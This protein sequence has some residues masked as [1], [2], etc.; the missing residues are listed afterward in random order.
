MRKL[1]VAVIGATGTVGQRII[2]LLNNH[3]YFEVTE[4]FASSRSAGKPYNQTVNW[5]IGGEPS[6]S[7]NDMIVRG[8]DQTPDSSLVFSALPSEIAA[9][10][11]LR[12]ALRGK[13]VISKSSALRY[14][15]D[16]PLIVP[17]VNTNHLRL[18]NKQ[19]ANRKMKGC[20]ITDPNCTTTGLVLT[21]AP[22]IDIGLKEVFVNTMQALSGAGFPGVASL[23][24]QDNIIPYIP[25]EE[26]KIRI[27]SKKILGRY[28]RNS[29]IE[30]SF[31]VFAFCS[32]VPVLDCHTESVHLRFDC[33]IDVHEA[34]SILSNF[35]SE[36]QRLKLHSAP[37][38]PVIVMKQSDRPQPRLDKDN[39]KGMSTTVGRLRQ[40][41]DDNSI[42]YT[43]C[44]HNTIRGAAGSSILDAE[45]LLKT[46]L[47]SKLAEQ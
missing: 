46:G 26:E 8:V 34:E 15:P 3:P 31:S 43:L 32:R 7:V 47:L 27:E 38:K 4:L 25:G 39:G 10:V 5:L 23:S 41:I 11:E 33:Q 6:Q 44:S 12:N 45:F 24:I 19:K 18:L 40:G 20:I 37:E 13:V 29:I 1:G 28:A 2:Q 21:L 42:A 22:F 16:V 17:E 35:T 14:E 9:E 36:P 30:A